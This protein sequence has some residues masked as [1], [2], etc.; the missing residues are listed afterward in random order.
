MVQ[1]RLLFYAAA[2]FEEWRKTMTN[3][4]N[5]IFPTSRLENWSYTWMPSIEGN[6]SHIFSD[7]YLSEVFSVDGNSW[8][9]LKETL[10]CALHCSLLVLAIDFDDRDSIARSG[11]EVLKLVDSEL[12]QV[13]GGSIRNDE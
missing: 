2:E 12:N 4:T 6:I 10:Q 5:Q 11:R 1:E 13:V 9:E 8:R 7:A 3:S